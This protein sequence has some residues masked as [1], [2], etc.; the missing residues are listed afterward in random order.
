M[1]D[2]EEMEEFEFNEGDLQRAFN[3]GFKRHKMTKEEAMLGIWA[4]REFSDS[5]DEDQFSYRKQKKYSNSNIDFVSSKKNKKDGSETETSGKV[6]EK[7]SDDD[8]IR[9]LIRNEE[10]L[11]ESDSDNDNMEEL[12]TKNYYQV[13]QPV[14]S[15]KPTAQKQEPKIT[16]ADVKEI[17]NWERHTKGIGMKLMQ[18]MG[19]EKGKGLGKDLAG[20]AIPV[21]AS[22]RKGKG[23]IGAHGPENKERRHKEV[24]DDEPVHVSQWKKDKKHKKPQ[25]TLKTPEELIKLASKQ[26]EKLRKIEKLMEI[27]ELEQLERKKEKTGKI[28]IIDMTSREQRVSHGYESLSQITKLSKMESEYEEKKRENFDVPELTHNLDLILNMT[29]DKLIHYDKKMKHYEDMI[30]GLSYEEK[31]TREKMTSESDQMEKIKN[32]I[33]SI[34]ICE[35]KVSEEKMTLD[36]L[37]DSFDDLRQTYPDEFII[38][39][40]SQVSIPLMA[41]LIK[42][43]LKLWTPFTEHVTDD[44]QDPQSIIFCHDI[45]TKLKSLFNETDFE[46]VNLYHRF[47]WETW[48]PAFRKILSE[49]SI[50]EHSVDCSLLIDKWRPLLSSWII[51]NILDQI[52]LP[53]LIDEVELWNP[54]TDVI[55]IHEWVHPW[56][57]LMKDRLDSTLFPTIRFKLASALQSWHPSDQSAK[58]V[59]NPWKPPVFSAQNW[60]QFLLRNILP[61]L[62][63]VLEQEF[64]INPSKQNLEA[65]NW[66][67]SWANLVPIS[68]FVALLE[69]SFF[70][71]WLQVLSVWLNS[72][73]NYEE[74]SKW[75]VGWKSLFSEKLLQHPS[76]KAKLSQ[77]LMMMNRSVSGAQVSYNPN[78]PSPVVSQTLKEIPQSVREKGAQLSSTPV[79]SSFKDIIEKKAAEKN[80]MFMPIVNKFKEGKQVYRLGNLNLYLDRNVI[81]ILQNGNWIPASLNEIFQKAL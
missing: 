44:D 70:P 15:F 80:I 12:N 27:G 30:V 36:D 31:R 42:R 56:L 60:E 35:S 68:S 37:I 45:Y 23:A 2:E 5:E 13:K 72:S 33:K 54:L 75:Y 52:I 20:R 21:E 61:K 77:G 32:L 66:V 67:T 64:A 65:W 57:A 10:L 58:A 17:G 24:E 78:E 29:E 3:P 38:F 47:V 9:D 46:N 53:K 16:R 7:L 11:V 81:F 28:K 48:M 34:E 26:P 55:P 25:Y 74:V 4:S 18:K 40:L 73:P 76:I 39:N 59:L 41:P 8:E 51:Q 22:V 14:P 1:S 6:D 62:E 63:L 71:K 69:K 19:W 50:K 43:K 79:V 49:I